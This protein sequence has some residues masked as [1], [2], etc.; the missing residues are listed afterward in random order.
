MAKK[1][2]TGKAVKKET[3]SKLS[4]HK[5]LVLNRFMFHFFKD[6]TLQGLKNRLGEDRFEGIHE[7][8]QSLFFHEL[9]NYLFE[10]DLIDLDELRRYD[11]NIVQHWQQITEHRNRKEDTV[12]NMKYFQYLSLLFTEIYLDWYFN[13]KQQ[14]LDGLNNELAAYNAE[15]DK[16]AK[17]RANQFKSYVLDDLNK[18]AYWNATGSGKTLLLHVNILQYLHYFQPSL[19]G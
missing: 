6:G 18:L 15:N 17:D 1:P 4:F 14:L 9:S 2:T 3:N 12:L 11:L 5:Q 13:R 16:T 10:V 7:D 19:P 8:G